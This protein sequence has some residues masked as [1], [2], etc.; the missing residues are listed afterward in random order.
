MGKTQAHR[1][2]AASLMAA[3]LALPVRAADCQQDHATYADPEAA[4]T[5]QF[6]PQDAEA[7]AS[8]HRFTL[9][10]T[11]SKLVMEG[12]VMASEP[13]NRP[14]GMIFHNCPEGDVTGEDLAKC[15]VWQGV[16]YANRGGEIDLLPAVAANAAQ[17]I[18]LPNFGA[19]L[20]DS[21][22]WGDNKA[23]VVPWD[24]LTLKGCLP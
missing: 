23:T 17:E 18:L 12:Y 1:F 4:Y 16:I 19:S 11:A 6:H 7:S 13:V 22:A 3:S 21:T 8:T 15:T 9:T 24:V 2:L 5:L 14:N 10:V 20:R